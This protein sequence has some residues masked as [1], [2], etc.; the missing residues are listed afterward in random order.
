V[1]RKKQTHVS[2]LHVY[3]HMN[4]VFTTWTFLRF[5][6]GKFKL[7][8]HNHIIFYLIVNRLKKKK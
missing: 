6:K 4:M 1:L 5:I 8:K 7:H 2:F 3:H